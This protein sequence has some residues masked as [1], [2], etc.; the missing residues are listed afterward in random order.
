MT[1]RREITE[2]LS[3][4]KSGEAEAEHELLPL[5]HAELHSL[6]A[7]AMQ[8]QKPEHTLQPTAL[9]NEAYLRLFGGDA[10]WD[11]RSQF[12]AVAATAMRRI[13]IDHARTRGA[14]KRGGDA[15]K[16]VLTDYTDTP[17]AENIDLIALDE[18]L[19]ELSGKEPRA[20]RVVELRFFGG[21]TN[22]EVAEGLGVTTRTVERQWKFAQAWLRS[23]LS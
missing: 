18:A 3:R 23:R 5:V 4:L 6:A 11:S 13:L 20:A 22:D 17:G 9:V 15:K 2:I 16:V 21:L 19:D 12:F 8:T 1:R 10:V 7:R 14:Q